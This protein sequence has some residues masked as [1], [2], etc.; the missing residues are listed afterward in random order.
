MGL[1]APWKH[2]GRDCAGQ[3]DPQC[4]LDWHFSRNLKFLESSNPNI[5]AYANFTPERG[6]SLVMVVNLDPHS[7]QEGMARLASDVRCPV[8]PFEA[9]APR[10]LLPPRYGVRD[11]LM[12]TRH[13]WRSEWNYVRLDPRGVPAQI[14]SLEL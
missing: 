3:S 6:D 14:F 1:E 9:D 12:A 4:A 2:Q 7:A 10:P 8:D 11:V 5:I 13:E